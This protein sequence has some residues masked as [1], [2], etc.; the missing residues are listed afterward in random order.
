MVLPDVISA[1]LSPRVWTPT[2][3]APGV[4]S[5]VSSPG[6]LASPAFEPG[7]RLAIPQQ[8]LQLGSRFRSCSHSLMFRPA[9]LLATLV[10]PTRHLSVSGSRGFY[11]RPYHGWLPAPCSG[12]A[13][14]PNPGYWRQRDFHPSKSAALSAAPQTA[15]AT[16]AKP[17]GLSLLASFG[18]I[19]S[20]I[21]KSW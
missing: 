17:G 12:Y 10:A 5:P 20:R 9:N 18:N 3:A 19:G 7:R 2:P 4:H 1:D 13:S 14:R 21:D 6:T 15:T 8:L 16:P 11:F